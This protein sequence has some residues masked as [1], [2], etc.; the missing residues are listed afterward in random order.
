MDKHVTATQAVRNFSEI[1]NTIK[2]QGT[3]YVIE[4]GGKPIATMKPV[5]EE[6]SS[7]TLG[8]LKGLLKRLPKLDQELDSFAADLEDIC[9]DRLPL[10]QGEIWE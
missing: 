5:K 1:L 3:H 2:F 7:V 4:R 9:K 10:P 8:N 6:T